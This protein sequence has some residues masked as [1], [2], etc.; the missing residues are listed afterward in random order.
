MFSNIPAVLEVGSG[1]A[2]D[3][4]DILPDRDDKE[5]LPAHGFSPQALDALEEFAENSAVYREDDFFG[6]FEDGEHEASGLDG[7]RRSPAS[8][9]RQGHAPWEEAFKIITT[10]FKDMVGTVLARILSL[11]DFSSNWEYVKNSLDQDNAASQEIFQYICAPDRGVRKAT[12]A[13]NV[14]CEKLGISS[15]KFNALYN[16]SHVA[17]AMVPTACAGNFGFPGL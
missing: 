5:E 12:H 14:V 8:M 4:F 6:D 7:R 17:A 15:V 16:P 3:L 10:F 9:R 2:E 13:K 1:S 11:V